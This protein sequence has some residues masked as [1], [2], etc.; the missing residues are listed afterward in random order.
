MYKT[1]GSMKK[2]APESRIDMNPMF[3]ETK[4][5]K[6][7]VTLNSTLLS[8]LQMNKW[9]GLMISLIFLN[10]TFYFIY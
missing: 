6:G 1:Y 10:Y 4:K 2:E 8:L 7:V 5:I 3:K 9:V